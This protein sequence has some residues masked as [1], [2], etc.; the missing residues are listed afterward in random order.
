MDFHGFSTL[1]SHLSADLIFNFQRV[2]SAIAASRSAASLVLTLQVQLLSYLRVC[3]VNAWMKLMLKFSALDSLRPI[4]T[5]TST[6][7]Q[8]HEPSKL[9]MY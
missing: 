8:I 5:N 1:G 6:K 3:V 7:P 2:T 4:Q 9:L